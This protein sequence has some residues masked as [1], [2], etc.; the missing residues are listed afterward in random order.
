MGKSNQC[1]PKMLSILDSE[2]N[3]C[4]SRRS[5]SQ[6]RKLSW[7]ITLD[8]DRKTRQSSGSGSDCAVMTKNRLRRSTSPCK[9]IENNPFDTCTPKA[10]EWIQRE[11]T[12]HLHLQRLPMTITAPAYALQTSPST[13]IL[14]RRYICIPKTQSPPQLAGQCPTHQATGS[15]ILT[16]LDIYKVVSSLRESHKDEIQAMVN[17]AIKE[18]VKPLLTKI[19]ELK[20]RIHYL[21]SE[22][23]AS[24][25]YSRRNCV[26]GAVSSTIASQV[27]QLLNRKCFC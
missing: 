26:L 14:L 21:E 8:L 10:D 1:A 6:K 4:N 3:N 13:Y 15:S 25:Q 19:S 16:D 20:S 17:I 22:M 7:I 12:R 23:D 24:N 11:A 5:K 9:H 18:D 27:S 2:S